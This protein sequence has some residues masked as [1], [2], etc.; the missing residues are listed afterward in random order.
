M[1]EKGTKIVCIDPIEG[2]LTLGKEYES[3]GIESYAGRVV[4][5]EDN[6]REGHFKPE[7]FEEAKMKQQA[8]IDKWS[9]MKHPFY[10]DYVLTGQVKDHPR[11]SDMKDDVQ[12]TSPIL[13]IDFVNKKA[14]T[15]N[16]IYELLTEEK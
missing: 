15:R 7:R 11:Q 13:S 16:T 9:I 8:K 5:I 1:M 2:Y 6:G 10:N 14:E 12:V 3:Q 4:I